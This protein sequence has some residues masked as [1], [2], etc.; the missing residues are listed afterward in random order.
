MELGKSF[1]LSFSSP[2]VYSLWAV[3]MHYTSVP[4]LI[5]SAAPAL[6]AFVKAD[7]AAS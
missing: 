5:H 7:K 4:F 2:F 3:V 6:T 1:V